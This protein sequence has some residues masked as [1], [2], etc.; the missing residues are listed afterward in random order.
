MPSPIFP[1]INKYLYNNSTKSTKPTSAADEAGWE[2]PKTA[3]NFSIVFSE[4]P[5]KSCNSDKSNI[6]YNTIL[7]NH[8]YFNV[9]NQK[10]TERK[11][12]LHTNRTKKIDRT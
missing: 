7:H 10:Y 3:S 4:R 12:I 11:S 1:P 6:K 2:Q 8:N 5:E 9:Y